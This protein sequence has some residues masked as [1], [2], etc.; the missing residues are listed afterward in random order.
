MPAAKP[1]GTL[2]RARKTKSLVMRFG[3]VAD[4]L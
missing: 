2:L 1:I 3:V 4:D